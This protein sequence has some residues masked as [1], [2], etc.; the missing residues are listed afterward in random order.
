MIEIFICQNSILERK[1]SF[2][3]CNRRWS[4]CNHNGRWRYH[5]WCWDHQWTKI[6]FDLETSWY[7]CR[8]AMQQLQDI[9][10]WDVAYRYSMYACHRVPCGRMTKGD[11]STR[12]ACVWYL[13]HLLK[14]IAVAYMDTYC[15]IGG[16]LRRGVP[17]SRSWVSKCWW[18]IIGIF[19][20]V[21]LS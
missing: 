5:R 6:Y 14:F 19:H 16:G 9:L 10:P 18:K 13:R 3:W 7:R 21:F 20:P 17:T 1:E 15:I 4:S 2:T 8:L 11:E 12:I